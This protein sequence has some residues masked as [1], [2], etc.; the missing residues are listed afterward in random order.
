MA[1]RAVGTSRWTLTAYATC[2][3]IVTACAAP[4]IAFP[5][6]S[7]VPIVARV[8]QPYMFQL[9]D[10]TFAPQAT[11]FTY[12]LSDQP[13][14][15]SVDGSTRT[16]SGTPTGSDAGASTFT[17]TAVDDT[18]AAHMPCTLVVSSDPA[19]QIQG[20][21]SKQ[22]AA[23]ANLSSTQPPVVT[24]L[25]S[26]PFL[27]SFQ[28]DSF[29]D[30]V[31]RRLYYYATLTDHTPLPAW[32]SF[33]P[34]SLAFSGMAPLLSAFPQSWDVELIASDVAGFAGATV[35]F[36]ITVG[37]Q[38]LAFVP[39]Q[40]TVNISDG[41]SLHFTALQKGLF[42]NGVPV[43]I[44][45]LATTRTSVLPSWLHF[46]PSSLV[47][48]GTVPPQS[49]DES[50]SVT[51]TDVLGDSATAVV[52]LVSGNASL[53]SSTIGT[54]TAYPGQPFNYRFAD[55]L[56][57]EQ[58]LKLSVTLPVTAKWLRFDSNTRV[59]QG[60]MPEQA[61]PTAIEATL[62][63]KSAALP[64]GQTQAF[65]ID[66]KASFQ[67]MSSS[68]RLA[69]RASPTN[70]STST[71]LPA[72]ASLHNHSRLSAGVIAAIVI[73]SMVVIAF[74][75]AC[76]LL[77]LR[78]RRRGGYERHSASPVKRKTISRPILQTD[79]PNVITVTTD[80]QTDIEKTAESDENL[81][82]AETT[83]PPPQIA[84]NLPSHTNSKHSKW[85]NRL[86]HI[87]QTSSIGNGEAAIRSD[88]NIPEWG[89]DSAAALHTPHNSFSVP[90]EMARVSRQLSQTSPTKRALQRIRER[91]R[92]RQSVGL[93]IDTGGA[94]LMPR[95]S[96]RQGRG[97][98]RG[99][100]SL[101]LSAAM[102]R[103]SQISMSTRGTSVLSTKPSEFPR[104]P[105]EST[106]GTK[107]RSIPTLSL[108]EADKRRSIRLVGRSDS[109]NDERPMA[110]K[111]QSFI[112][113]RASGMQSPLFA[114]GSRAPSNTYPTGQ[115]SAAASSAG[116]SVRR[117]RRGKSTLTSYSESSSLEPQGRDSRRLSARIRSTFAPNFPR[118]VTRSSLGADDEGEDDGSSSGFVTTSSSISERDGG[119]ELD[120]ISED[121][122]RAE[123]VLPRHERSWVY[124]DEASPT[125]PPPAPPPTSRQVSSVRASTEIPRQKKWKERLAERT[126]SPLST[127]IAV[128]V[129]AESSISP[130]A[131]LSQTQAQGRRQSRLSEPVGL[132]GKE[133]ASKPERPRLVQ[134]GSKRPVSVDSVQR[135]SSSRAETDTGTGGERWEDVDGRE[136][137]GSGLL[138]MPRA[139]GE[140]K[141]NTHRSDMSGP[142]F[143]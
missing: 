4:S 83:E 18:G 61:T 13:A 14:W 21:W 40:Q 1:C 59:L 96:S 142:A 115:S 101:G 134:T 67:T 141:G 143:L 121:G 136:L 56:F 7:Q 98:R 106:I 132:A 50:V 126:P 68:S 123:M 63:A 49:S 91:H 111:R 95:H 73:L 9:S 125:P 66:I 33:D 114:H 87:S 92:S 110:E 62:M 74:L 71:P 30:I 29:I 84:L 130:S 77:C 65:T 140:S 99:T 124:P 12:S 8:D 39:S 42:R 52:N 120:R 117:S 19:P 27:F 34:Q 10:S 32:L 45:E 113:N 69:T 15:L 138:M 57:N 82:S 31:Q 72:P 24:V 128:P 135:M 104:P 102:D 107:R 97:H 46:D 41:M 36:T 60:T 137:E 108:T 43:K 105:T 100:S 28:Q 112:R 38:Q 131:R 93:G 25:P 127:A 94:G 11:N 26:S 17:L 86:S 53:F 54:L 79:P 81:Q 35:S 20:D 129:V 119:F 16:L 103:S 5:F 75:I 78:R 109:V 80:L 3:F 89:L 76:L 23:T 6:N 122:L 116:G 70:S 51:V 48:T 58:D 22:L 90:A 88:R 44:S 37:M 133:S 55:T 2:S 139:G 64:T 118:P 85:F 47:L